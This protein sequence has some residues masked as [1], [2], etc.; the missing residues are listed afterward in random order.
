MASLASGV[1]AITGGASGMG[2]ATARRLARAKA[3]AIAIG[4][5]NDK[6]FEEVQK[7]LQSINPEVKVQLTKLN[8]ASSKE[9]N[10][11][12]ESIVDT[13]GGLDGAVNAAGVAQALGARQ[14][15]A[16][17]AESD[18]EWTRV[19]GVNLDGVFFCNRAQIKAMIALPKK[20]RS[21]VNIASMAAFIHGPDCYSYGIS[22]AGV[23][24]MTAGL[25][26][27]VLSFGIRVN[28]VSPSA[29]N[30]P[31]LSQFFASPPPEGQPMD[32]AGFQLVEADDIA[33][34]IEWLLSE[35]SAQVSGVN[36]PVGS[37]PP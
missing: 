1:F 2:L 7:E 12:I 25:A 22:K 15:P 24:Y 10:A 32:T 6:P 21:I 28:T 5:Y 17:L 36:V 26:K 11:W 16:I 19:R 35:N 3:K 4:D 18:E 34:C 20:P 9:V 23:A 30:T 31:M 14:P 33:R 29:T 8:V 37:S 13:F 27:D